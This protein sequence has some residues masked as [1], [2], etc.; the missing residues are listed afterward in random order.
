M[1]KVLWVEQAGV[2]VGVRG[3]RGWGGGGGG[4]GDECKH[5]VQKYF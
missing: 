3:L 2:W 1:I 5:V 4:G